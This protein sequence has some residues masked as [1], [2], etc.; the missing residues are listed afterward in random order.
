MNSNRFKDHIDYLGHLLDEII[1]NQEGENVFEH[2]QAILSASIQ[3]NS[4][5]LNAYLQKLP[6]DCALKVIRG[7]SFFLQLSNIAEDEHHICRRRVHALKASP[8]REGSLEHALKEMHALGVLSSDFQH[9]LQHTE[10]V[11]VLTAHPTEVQRQSLLKHHRDIE[12]LLEKR[13]IA[14]LTQE[15]LEENEAAL[16]RAILTL[17][18]SRM[19]RPT[20]LQVIDEINNGIH[21]FKD[22][23]WLAIPKLY[24]HFE[25]VL[26]K[27]GLKQADLPN[28]LTMGSWIGGDRDG[29]PYVNAE[30]LQ[31]ALA[32]QADALLQFY[33][34][35]V[36]A[37]FVELPLSEL[38]FP[39]S[40]ALAQLAAQTPD[41]SPHRA[42]E[43][44][45][46]ALV[47]I[48]GRL[49]ATHCILAKHAQN[50]DSFAQW[51]LPEVKNAP[52]YSCSADF[53]KDLNLLL[54]ALDE[55]ACHALEEGRL[56]TLIRA[57]RVFGFHMASLDLR[58]NADMHT[59]C[60]AELLKE[61]GI[62]AHYEKLNENERQE[63]LLNMLENP[64]PVYSP[65][66]E[67]SETLKKELDIF[68]CLK[69]L[70]EK[71]GNKALP[72]TI[73]SMTQSVVNLLEVAFLFKEAG[74][75]HN[76][77]P[78]L[79]IVPL[80]ETI[81]DLRQSAQIMQ[82]FFNIPLCR[83][84]L[85]THN[86]T[87]EVMLGYSDSN[88]DG[89]FLTSGWELYQAEIRL[90]KTF[91]ENGVRL[92]LFHGRG[93]SIGRGGGPAWQAVLAQPSGALC[94]QMR[95]T[96]QGEVISSKY[97]N[98][99]NAQ[100]NL[101][102][103]LAATLLGSLTDQENRTENCQQFYPVMD[104]LAQSAFHNYRALVYETDGFETY[105]QESTILSEI[106]ALNIG[107]RPASRKK[108]TKI[109]DLRAIPWVFSWAQCRLMLPGW[110]GFGSA[111][112]NYLKQHPNGLKTLQKMHQNWPFFKMLLSNIDMVLAKTDLAIGKE[113][114]QLVK[115]KALRERIFAQIEK[116]WHL[117]KKYLLRILGAH[118][119]LKDDP[120]LKES[121]HLRLPYIN[122]LN[123]LQV[124]LLRR[125]RL[126]NND[127][128]LSRAIHLSINGIA[129]GLRNTG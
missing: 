29:N 105:F 84:W 89:G 12:S 25:R 51:S 75:W 66:I 100:R 124:E 112:E 104:F 47:W 81:T 79:E 5:A 99:D 106:A 72:R 113:Y 83:K 15:E 65:W 91:Q 30:L 121:L 54:V 126:N 90:A 57:V 46:R 37:L 116:E 8:A 1:Q 42:D 78:D 48:A 109:E 32:M 59:L 40:K 26:A 31:T 38:L 118:H 80:F 10:V 74:V 53:L 92:R 117:S 6:R 107:S 82:Q 19:L 101:E 103:L 20:R 44:F 23:L 11:P 73:I 17:W 68:F 85:E 108:S 3:N 88:K 76:H 71:Y 120:V 21:V 93:G 128:R 102:V 61:S 36:R 97:G 98:P 55:G 34:K 95:L 49:N 63:L 33:L 119:F 87:Q 58:Q 86:N 4:D 39:P 24:Q 115:D 22:T 52:A 7:F 27:N 123:H 127:T 70:R 45:R 77:A 125:Y 50:E 2:I 69:E 14:D 122:A 64:R 28:V 41:I 129:S 9:L 94:G 35:E 56:K 110:Y 16:N 43:P 13:S 62:C 111:V 96:E 114:A 67:Y 18:Y 60:V